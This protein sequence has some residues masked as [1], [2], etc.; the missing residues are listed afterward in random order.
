MPSKQEIK[1]ETSIKKATLGSEW[2]PTAWEVKRIVAQRLQANRMEA[3]D[4]GSQ[5]WRMRKAD[6]SRMEEWRLR[7]IVA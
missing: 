6:F 4:V 5:E 1:G 7:K 3:G 2:R